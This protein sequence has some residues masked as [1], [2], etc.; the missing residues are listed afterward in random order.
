MPIVAIWSLAEP[1]CWLR[2]NET[3]L[4]SALC[5]VLGD[6]VIDVLVAVAG[7]DILGHA[8]F[9]LPAYLHFWRNL[10]D[11]LEVALVRLHVE[12]I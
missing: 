10:R 2:P 7:V 8:V 5:L 9:T 4:F 11:T 3:Q 12:I 6:A 1:I